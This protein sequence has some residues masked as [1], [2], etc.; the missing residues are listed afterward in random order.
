MVVLPW[1][2]ATATVR[3]WRRW[4][5]S[6]SARR[7]TGMPR[8]SGRDH[9]RVGAG[10]GRRDQRGRRPS[11]TW[12]RPRGRRGRS[13]PRA[14]SRREGGGVLQVGAA[15]LLA[16]ASEHGGDGAH[17]GAAGT[18]DVDGAA[19]CSRATVV[20]HAGPRGGV[21]EQ[22]GDLLGGV[23][24]A[25]G[26]GGGGHRLQRP[27]RVDQAPRPPRPARRRCS[28][29]RARPGRRRPLRAG[30]RR[31]P[32][33][34]RGAIGNGTSTDGTPTAV[35]SAS[36]GAAGSA[37]P[38][39]GGGEQQGDPVA[40]LD[41]PVHTAQP[42]ARPGGGPPGRASRGSPMAWWMATSPAAGPARGQIED[43]V[44]DAA[45]AERPPG[46]GHDASGRRARRAPAGRRRG[47]RAG[48]CGRA[49]SAR[50]GLPV[51]RARG[52]PVP[53]NATAAAR[54]Q[55]AARPVGRRRGRRWTRPPRAGCATP[56]Q[57]R[58]RARPA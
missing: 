49:T 41:P 35:N 22:G 9:L 5:P 11:P 8:S 26:G 54:A 57:Q 53:S 38:D 28:Q 42:A 58:R 23:R 48:G 31:R 51:R 4:P 46:H 10:H 25:V 19:G 14:L 44:V 12:S 27:G 50:T 18:D 32:G 47:P 52:S 45:G 1:V 30:G 56:G 36:G 17:A 55:R 16:H 21:L 39:V 33:G 43:G 6:I 3:R 24:A 20:S 29:R 13:T 15:H 40:V 37:D 2:P 7:S 34:R